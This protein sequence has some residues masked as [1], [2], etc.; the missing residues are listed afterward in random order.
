MA[1]PIWLPVLLMLVA[2]GCSRS[3]P[4]ESKVTA[5]SPISFAMWRNELGTDLSS[6]QWQEFDQA[7]QEI[8]FQV[9]AEFAATGTEAVDQAM[10]ERVNGLTVREVFEQGA[11]ARLARLKGDREQLAHFLEV[12]ATMRTRPDDE[13]SIAYL[14]QLHERQVARLAAVDGEIAQQTTR[15]RQLE[16]AAGSSR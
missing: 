1:R 4:L 13:A 14:Q 15:L 5:S 3:G 6:E 9:A 7:I 16:A 11:R 2:A 10:R 8:K 12:N